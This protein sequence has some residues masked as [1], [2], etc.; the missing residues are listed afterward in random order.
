MLKDPTFKCYVK[1]T[2]PITVKKRLRSGK[3]KASSISLFPVGAGSTGSGAKAKSKSKS[4]LDVTIENHDDIENDPIY[5]NP[6]NSGERGCC[7]ANEIYAEP[8]IFI[9]PNVDPLANPGI[10]IELLPYNEQKFIAII[11][12]SNEGFH[13]EWG[14]F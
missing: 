3:T 2:T 1:N 8:E 5:R 11:S 7:P 12:L 14:E 6:Y 9:E 10:I 13:K 4:T